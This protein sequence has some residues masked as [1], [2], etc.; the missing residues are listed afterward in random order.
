MSNIIND[1]DKIAFEVRNTPRLTREQLFSILNKCYTVVYNSLTK[2]DYEV[3]RNFI[4]EQR[5]K[6]GRNRYYI[7]KSKETPFTILLRYI[8]REDKERNNV[9]RY[10]HALNYLHKK[11][12]KPE[13]FL[14][15]LIEEGG[16]TAIYW[17]ERNRESKVMNLNVI[18]LNTNVTLTC[19]KPTMLILMPRETTLCDVIEIKNMD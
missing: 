15:K 18:R 2:E 9:S 4:K 1:L 12:V 3:M 5:S 7:L 14:E 6:E 16:I 13:D 8:F 10:I 19:N 11:Q 17:K